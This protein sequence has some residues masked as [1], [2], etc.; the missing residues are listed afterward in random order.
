MTWKVVKERIRTTNP[1]P[2]WNKVFMLLTGIEDTFVLSFVLWLPTFI[3]HFMFFVPIAWGSAGWDLANLC[4]QICCKSV[5]INLYKNSCSVLFC[6][7]YVPGGA[8][9]P[10]HMI[11]SVLSYFF[12]TAIELYDNSFPFLKNNG[13]WFSCK[14]SFEYNVV[15]TLRQD[16]LLL[17]YISSAYLH[18]CV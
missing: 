16:P 4:L 7:F 17:Q 9:R 12:E 8:I 14:T 11:K 10:V 5:I 15:M 3:N 13:S 2:I 1:F 18:L 6:C